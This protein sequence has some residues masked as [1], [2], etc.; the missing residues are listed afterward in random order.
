GFDLSVSVDPKT[1]TLSPSAVSS[2]IVSVN[3]LSGASQ[4]VSLS[5]SISPAGSLVSASLSTPTGNPSF[6]STLS[7]QTN[8]NTPQGTYVITIQGMSGGSVRTTSYVVNV[9]STTQD[10]SLATFPTNA[11]LIFQGG[12]ASAFVTVTP[13]GDR[14]STRLNSSHVSTSYAV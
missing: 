2:A 11:V 14:N 7:V 12:I 6:T 1:T 4:P 9:A 13:K 8:G 5:T 10:F 3:L